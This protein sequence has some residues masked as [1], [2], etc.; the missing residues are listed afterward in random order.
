M[1]QYVFMI[2]TDEIKQRADID[3][4][5][6]DKTIKTAISDAQDMI[7]EQCIGSAL[8]EKLIDGIKNANLAVAYQNLLNNKIRPMLIHATRYMLTMRLLYRASAASIASKSSEGSTP[9]ST[10]DLNVIRSEDE[11]RMKHF[12]NKL[13]LYLLANIDTYPEYTTVN[14]DGLASESSPSSCN[15]YIEE[16]ADTLGYGVNNF[17]TWWYA[18]NR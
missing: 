2:S 9:V 6:S 8:Y 11:M 16:S 18:N 13:I 5:V 17:T 4:N 12:V 1:A 14:Q 10:Q 7:L 3:N 15:V